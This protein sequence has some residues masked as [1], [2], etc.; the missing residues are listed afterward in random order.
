MIATS[1]PASRGRPHHR[2]KIKGKCKITFALAHRITVVACPA[3]KFVRNLSKLRADCDAQPRHAACPAPSHFG[4][5]PIPPTFT[6]SAASLALLH[7]LHLP[8]RVAAP[9]HT[10]SDDDTRR[11]PLQP[12]PDTNLSL[13]TAVVG[14]M[15]RP[16]RHRAISRCDTPQHQAQAIA[17]L[18]AARRTA[19]SPPAVAVPISSPHAHLHSHT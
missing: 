3:A 1:V 11:R 15:R 6:T 14:R 7:Q 19:R 18:C 5:L 4:V 8:P 13:S 16:V 12:Y 9:S 2:L 10:T 17:N